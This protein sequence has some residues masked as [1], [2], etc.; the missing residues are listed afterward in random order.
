MSGTRSMCPLSGRRIQPTCRT[1]PQRVGPRSITTVTRLRSSEA[2]AYLPVIEAL[3]AARITRF[4]I[5][6]W[7]AYIAAGMAIH[8]RAR[9]PR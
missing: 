6:E 4:T 3:E 5:A 8:K 7:D 2:L 1:I 9:R